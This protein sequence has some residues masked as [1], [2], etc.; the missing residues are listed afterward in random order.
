MKK[1]ELMVRTIF[2]M[3]A[4]IISGFA[5]SMGLEK[6]QLFLG[7]KIPDTIRQIVVLVVIYVTFV[8]TTRKIYK[9]FMSLGGR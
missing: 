3:M 5:A 7:I 1:K 6:I 4:I 9:H 2:A 8:L